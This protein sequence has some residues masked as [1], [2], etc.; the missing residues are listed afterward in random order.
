MFV[1]SIVRFLYIEKQNYKGKIY[2]TMGVKV[3]C[4]LEISL[5]TRMDLTVSETPGTSYQIQSYFAVF[6]LLFL[7]FFFIK[8]VET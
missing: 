2:F 6:N 7:L 1:S 8:L 4:S 3:L 5:R